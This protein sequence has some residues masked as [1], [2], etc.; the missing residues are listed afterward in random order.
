MTLPTVDG[1]KLRLEETEIG[2]WGIGKGYV[3]CSEKLFEVC[4]NLKHRSICMNSRLTTTLSSAPVSLSL[5]AASSS[6]CRAFFVTGAKN[7]SKVRFFEGASILELTLS[8]NHSWFR[9]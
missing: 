5:P 1:R 8:F 7:E 9:G 3:E 6:P 2:R 4:W